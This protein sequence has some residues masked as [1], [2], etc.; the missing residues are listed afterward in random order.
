MYDLIIT[1]AGPAGSSAARSAARM[2]LKTLILEK[3]TFPRY[4]PCGGALSERAASLLD[5]P[6]PQDICE[7]S[8]T[9][10]RVHLG[11]RTIERHKGYRL[12]RLVTRSSFDQYLLERAEEA[13]AI[14]LT[15]RVLGYREEG[16]HVS[17][18]TRDGEHR[19][20][21]LILASGCQ[22]RLGRN[23]GAGVRMGLSVLAEIPEDDGRIEERL[24]GCLDMHFD[25]AGMGYGWIFPH[26]GYYSVGIWGLGLGNARA[27]MLQFLISCGFEGSY[28][29]HGHRIPMGAGGG[30]VASGRVLRTGDSAGFV[31][32][33]T[34][35]GIYY[36]LLSGQLA[37]R[38]V[39]EDEPDGVARMYQAYCRRAILGELRSAWLLS[40]LVHSHR[41][42]LLRGLV[43][44]EEALDRYIGIAASRGT[45][46]EFLGWL[47]R[48][49][50]LSILH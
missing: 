1:G 6:L 10:V 13:G 42:A 47:L 17:V 22:D 9:G 32:P 49:I 34:G 8:I 46:G 38:A 15:G 14:H 40:R 11:G 12:T 16:D 29:L 20:R 43:S 36:A 48:R 28:R 35:E 21:F 44:Q 37:A 25:V 7:R 31:D 27:S 41:E 3:E 39:A 24:S 23:A 2:G 5:F 33:F 18:L 30:G 19:S 26:R 45:Y 4:K 50:P